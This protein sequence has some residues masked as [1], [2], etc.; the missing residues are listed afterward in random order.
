MSEGMG[1]YALA[2]ASGVKDGAVA[3]GGPRA[4]PAIVAHGL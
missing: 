1:A 2:V 3:A 4:Q